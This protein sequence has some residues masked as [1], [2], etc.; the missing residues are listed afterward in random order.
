MA[1][2]NVPF[3]RYAERCLDP[4]QRG[5]VPGRIP[6]DNV[7]GIGAHLSEWATHHDAPAG[8]M[9]LDVEAA[10]PSVS[11]EW[12]YRF[13]KHIG[14]PAALCMCVRMA[15]SGLSTTVSFGTS[16]TRSFR[17]RAGVRQ[18]CPASGSIFAMLLDPWVRLLSRRLSAPDHVI[19]VYADDVAVG[20][21]SLRDAAR[22]L[23]AAA[24]VLQRAT[25]LRMKGSKCVAIPCREGDTERIADALAATSVFGDSSVAQSARYLGITLGPRGDASQ[26]R[27]ALA[28]FW[29]R[30]VDIVQSSWSQSER[31][32]IFKIR[33]VSVLRYLLGFRPPSE[34]LIRVYSRACQRLWKVPFNSIPTA[35]M[36]AVGEVGL[37]AVPCLEDLGC[38]SRVAN[39]MLSKVFDELRRG[40]ADDERRSLAPRHAEWCR[41]H[42][43]SF[44]VR[45]YQAHPSAVFLWQAVPSRRVQKRIL[46]DLS[47]SRGK[48]DF[49][50]L[51]RRRVVAMGDPPG[52]DTIRAC[53]A[54]VQA[55]ARNC[56]PAAVAVLK[57][58]CNAWPL[59]GRFGDHRRPCAFCGEASETLPHL[60]KC[61][62]VRAAVRRHLGNRSSGFGW[63][64]GLRSVCLA[65][66]DSLTCQVASAAAECVLHTALRAHRHGVQPHLLVHA[67]LRELV[68]RFPR[69]LPGAPVLRRR[70]RRRG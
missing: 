64:S 40:F 25:G 6:S 49:L 22:P 21:R 14:A 7:L 60:A 5:F 43:Y 56:M 66:G 33:A 11:H 35:A 1:A 16:C 54:S 46:G 52:D 18:G 30:T 2:I 27:D 41:S 23:A 69:T 34:E 62:S 4:R 63:G 65:I 36:S 29:E 32:R 13:F 37:V 42:L 45:F 31:I 28:K 9:L 20:A 57:L 47:E 17:L 68:R 38:A 51:L 26:S 59:A 39:V 12:L 50:G 48:F 55:V 58:L 10:F 3:R 24:V 19:A 67:R 53:L 70:R 15:Y 8:V 61:P 44:G